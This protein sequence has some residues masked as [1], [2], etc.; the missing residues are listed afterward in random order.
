MTDGAHQ[1]IDAESA[2]KFIVGG[3]DHP[4]QMSDEE[5]EQMIRKAPLEGDLD[6]SGGANAMARI[7]LEALE[8]HPQLRDLPDGHEY[9]MTSD[10]QIFRTDE[11]WSPIA[12][13]V[14]LYDVIKRLH[15]EHQETIF[16]NLTGFMWGWAVNASRKILGLGPVPNPAIMTIGASE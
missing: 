7:L 9:L 14:D 10:G 3:E 8:K 4:E 12:L 5:F 11:G 2:M 1:G 13:N 15:P 16:D 6:Y